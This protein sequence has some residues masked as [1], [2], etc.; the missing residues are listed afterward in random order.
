MQIFGTSGMEDDWGGTTTTNQGL[1][2]L[3]DVG[4]DC[5][6]MQAAFCW[7]LWSEACFDF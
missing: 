7:S 2:K 3:S 4:F 5:D 6:V 1:V